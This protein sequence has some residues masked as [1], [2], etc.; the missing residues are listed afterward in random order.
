ML[1]LASGL[2]LAGCAGKPQPVVYVDLARVTSETLP[3]VASRS[4]TVTLPGAGRL[5]LPRL[6]QATISMG[7]V[8][9]ALE[10][11]RTIREE[12]KR[13]AFEQVYRRLRAS[14]FDRARREAE[15]EIGALE[16][17]YREA[18]N[19]VYRDARPLFEQFA[20]PAFGYRVRLSNLVGFPDPDPKS[21]RQPEEADEAGKQRFE[22]AK[23]LRA[24][25]DEVSALFWL[26]FDRRRA[27]VESRLSAEKARI[28]VKMVERQEA[29]DVEAKQQAREIV[30]GN[31][32]GNGQGTAL[33]LSGDLP[34]Q[35]AAGI[36]LGSSAPRS[37]PVAI[38]RS[39]WTE[40]QRQDLDSELRV[41]AAV[42]GYRLAS[43]S[44][45]GR[46]ATDEFVIWRKGYR[47]G[48]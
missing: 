27:E 13:T 3:N 19:A 15:I 30:N 29:L 24:D 47:A 10:R 25:L 33:E 12:N 46:D 1:V 2:G 38:R 31:G 40:A 9:P 36:D 11:A 6:P 28:R 37:I 32:N 42:H 22:K 48:L 7:S 20:Q 14:A 39:D 44:S 45:Q 26:E 21:K 41:W 16:P 17:G 23:A 5:S 35:P 43:H 18:M 34:A 8:E 4:E